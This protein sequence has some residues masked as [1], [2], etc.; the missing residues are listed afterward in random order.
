VRDAKPGKDQSEN[1]SNIDE[2]LTDTSEKIDRLKRE[3]LEK[4]K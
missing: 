1:I 2:R 3:N 4:S